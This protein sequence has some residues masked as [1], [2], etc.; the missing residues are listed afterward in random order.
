MT[1]STI[2]NYSKIDG[3]HIFIRNVYSVDR[4]YRI[5]EDITYGGNK[6][7]FLDYSIMTYGDSYLPQIIYHN[8]KNY[9]TIRTASYGDLTPDKFSEF[10]VAQQ[11]GL[12]VAKF[13][14][15]TFCINPT[16]EDDRA[17]I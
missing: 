7:S 5:T 8:N 2:A 14:T 15:Q 12:D 10:V 13:L 6:K 3:N 11:K 1:L 9:F 4:A 17:D 16:E